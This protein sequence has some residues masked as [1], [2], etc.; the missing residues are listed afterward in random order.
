MTDTAVA[1]PVPASTVALLRDVDGG[2][3]VCMLRR[4]G[5]SS[6]AAGAFVFPG[7]AVDAADGTGPDAYRIAGVREVLEEVGLLIGGAAEGTG[8]DDLDTRVSAAR[9]QVLGGGKLAAALA[10]HRLV[11]TPDDLVY[12]AHFITPPREG[13]RYD[14]RFFALRIGVQ[15][16]VRVHAAE[17]VEGGWHRPE[18]MLPLQFPAI[19]PP[20]R[21][22]CH[23]FARLGSVE[24]ILTTLGERPIEVTDITPEI[25]AGWMGLQ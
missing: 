12:I 17:A 10:G 16:A 7:G 6:F 9:A 19:M 22:M 1:A 13:R 4:P 8:D 2:V 20:T 3:E 18:A 25:I 24:A 21:M 5:R 11:I 15:Q 14:T 23:E